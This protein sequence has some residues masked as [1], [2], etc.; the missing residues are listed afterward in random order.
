[1]ACSMVRVTADSSCRP[2]TAVLC[3]SD[4]QLDVG[5]VVGLSKGCACFGQISRES[6]FSQFAFFD[7]G[8]MYAATLCS[9]NAKGYN[10]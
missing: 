6:A 1:M 5:K 4:A 8:N 9:V 10:S 3:R 2:P 7:I